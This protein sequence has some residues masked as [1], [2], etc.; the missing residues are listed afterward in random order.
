[1]KITKLLLS[2]IAAAF[3]LTGC[4][5]TSTSRKT[6]SESLCNTGNSDSDDDDD[7][8]KDAREFY[9]DIR[10][11]RKLIVEQPHTL[12][13]KASIHFKEGQTVYFK[14]SV[15]P[16]RSEMIVL[17]NDKRS[18]YSYSSANDYYEFEFTMP[19]SDTRLELYY[20][21]DDSHVN[22]QISLKD[23]YT[24]I[25]NINEEDITKVIT[26]SKHGTVVPRLDVLDEYY[27]SDSAADIHRVY[28]YLKTTKIVFD[29]PNVPVGAGPDVLTIEVLNPS[30]Q[31]E[32]RYSIYAYFGTTTQDETT[33]SVALP[34]MS[35]H[36]GYSFMSHMFYDL[37]VTSID[38]TVDYTKD[39]IKLG[40]LTNMIFE[41]IDN[42][43]FDTAINK[44]NKYKITCYEGS[45]IFQSETEFVVQ[46]EDGEIAA[47]QIVN[48]V[49]FKD[50]IV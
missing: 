23:R 16:L 34:K 37:K 13:G 7:S 11:P 49:T 15:P 25:N 32:E 35:N 41:K 31:T 10:D 26:S 19:R 29:Y 42:P 46:P 14:T 21:G 44:Y 33:L 8:F 5:T 24:W 43:N 3:L 22:E 2:F 12:N 30:T 27:Y 39:F 1:M 4:G 9:L 48:N 18:G 17:I 40:M 28:E 6:Y 20:R 36:Y 38:G 50:L 47:Y 45:I